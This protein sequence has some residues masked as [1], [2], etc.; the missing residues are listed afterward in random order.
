[1][2]LDC[3]NSIAGRFVY[4]ILRVTGYLTLCEVEVYGAV[5]GRSSTNI[6]QEKPTR[7]S[8]TA[9]GGVSWRAVDGDRNTYWGGSSCTHSCRQFRPWWRV[10]LQNVYDVS[11]V[12]ITN[13]G[14]CC[15]N[16]LRQIEVRVGYVDNHPAAN[17]L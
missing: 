11:E 7:Q 8:S 12:K 15:S 2:S 16:R 3:A 5:R 1:M 4:I 13:R 9:Y 14:D 6:A 10:D 17:T